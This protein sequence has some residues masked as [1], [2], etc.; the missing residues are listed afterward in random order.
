MVNYLRDFSLNPPIEAIYRRLGYKKR[1]TEL[2]PAAREKIDH[3]IDRGLA[4]CAP[5]AA[6]LI[7]DFTVEAASIVI[8]EQITMES[9]NLKSFLGG[10]EKAAIM[11]ATAG[12]KITEVVDEKMQDSP[13]AAVI[14][15]AVGSEVA[16]AILNRLMKHLNRILI[17]EGKKLSKSR[18]SPGYGDLDL[19]IQKDLHSF[20]NMENIGVVITEN[21]QLV[22][23]KSVIAI[24]GVERK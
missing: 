7:C 9:I 1:S 22:P 8:E 3:H 2:S 20:L 16:D 4:L 23:E 12:S 5:Q 17:T 19:S 10:Y 18:Y 24:A 11:G 13:F 6:W 14:Y 15:D 21:C